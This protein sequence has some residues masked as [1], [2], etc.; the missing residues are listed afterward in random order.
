MCED[1]SVDTSI[2]A[3]WGGG[4]V[5]R[6]PSHSGAGTVATLLPQPHATERPRGAAGGTLTF[7]WHV[8]VATWVLPH[9]V[10]HR[11]GGRL[12][13]FEARCRRRLGGSWASCAA[14]S[15]L[16]RTPALYQRRK[17]AYAAH[18]DRGGRWGPRGR[19]ALSQCDE[20]AHNRKAVLRQWRD[21]AACMDVGVEMNGALGS[22]KPPLASQVRPAARGAV[23]LA[24]P[25]CSSSKCRQTGHGAM[26]AR[27]GNL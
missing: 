25:A 6:P 18:L 22:G 11:Q 20:G 8:T 10:R 14:P 7:S 27:S 24:A 3:S 4:G 16:R 1:T 5:G 12:G 19:S 21:A 15:G 17:Q 23:P 9:P 26:I 13:H 2:L